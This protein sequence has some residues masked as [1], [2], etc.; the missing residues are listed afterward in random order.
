MTQG[1]AAFLHENVGSYLGLTL[2]AAVALFF[3]LMIWQTAFGQN[4]VANLMAQALAS[5]EQISQQL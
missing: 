2:V 3:G 1:Q 4:P 5:Q